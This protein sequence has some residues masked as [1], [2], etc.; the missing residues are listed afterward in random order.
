M[1]QSAL[2]TTAAHRPI[3]IDDVLAASYTNVQAPP[4]PTVHNSALLLIDIQ[5]LAEPDYLHDHAVE[6]G[7]P[8]AEVNEALRDYGARFN[9]AVGQAKKV[10]EKAREVGVPPIHVK[11]QA[12]SHNARDTG[13]LHRRMGWQYPPN[14]AATRFIEATKPAPDEIVITKTASGAFTG[15]SLDTTLRNM[16]IDYL[17]VCGFVTDECVETTVRVAL[18]LG[19][20]AMVIEDAT[21]TYRAEAHRATIDQLSAYGITQRAADTIAI[22]NQM[23]AAEG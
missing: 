9:A 23:G 1:T 12:L 20:L 15:T 13:A 11:I 19:Y 14:S 7:L 21:Q 8:S 3:T 6:A 22:F 5:H 16:G 4:P 17:F 2:E 10:L 18:D